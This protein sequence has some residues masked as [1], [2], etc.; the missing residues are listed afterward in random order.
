MPTS[1]IASRGVPAFEAELIWLHWSVT[2]HHSSH[3]IEV[4]CAFYDSS[5]GRDQRC[6]MLK[7]SR[8]ADDGGESVDSII[9]GVRGIRRS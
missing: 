8:S 6:R 4:C 9:C 5:F 7:S 2:P 1:E 3:Y